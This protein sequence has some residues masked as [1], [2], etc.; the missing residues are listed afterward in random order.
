M[1]NRKVMSIFLSA[2]ALVFAVVIFMGSG[3]A[4]AEPKYVAMIG[5]TS[6][7]TLAEA[8]EAAGT[9][10]AVIRLIDNTTEGVVIPAGADI[11]I[12]LKGH[13][14]NNRN[15]DN[16]E[17][18]LHTFENYGKLELLSS[19]GEG[20]IDNVTHAKACVMNQPGATAVI[21]GKLSLSRSNLPLPA[22]ATRGSWYN[23]CN[24]G[25]MTV[26][27]GVSV[28][29]NDARHTAVTTGFLDVEQLFPNPPEA[30]LTINGGYFTGKLNA[31]K[32]DSAGV[33]EIND[34][35]IENKSGVAIVSWNILKINGGTI[36]A[37]TPLN[38][39]KY[40]W[41]GKVANPPKDPTEKGITEINGGTFTCGHGRTMFTKNNSSI[42]GAVVTI[43]DGTFNGSFSSILHMGK[44]PEGEP[45]LTGYV[46]GG[47]FNPNPSEY[48][49][50]PED[51]D[52]I[53]DENGYTVLADHE[54][55]EADC[56]TP[57]TCSRCGAT[58]GAALGH[59]YRYAGMTWAKDHSA[60]ANFVCKHD[61][62]HTHQEAATVT[63]KTYGNSVCEPDRFTVYTAVATFGGV[64]YKDTKEVGLHSDN[65]SWNQVTY[66]WS[67]DNTL[68]VAMTA[69][70]N[71]GIKEAET[72]VVITSD[73]IKHATCKNEGAMLVTATFPD[74][75]AFVTQ[76]KEVEISKTDDHT[77]G[78]WEHKN[79]TH[80]HKLCVV[81]QE[82][83]AEE[84]HDWDAGKVTTE[85][86]ATATGVRTLT[87]KTCDATKEE[88]I[89]KLQGGSQP[90]SGEASVAPGASAEAADKA[91]TALADDADPK[92]SMFRYL[93]LRSPSQKKNSVK[94]S[95]RKVGGAA[96]Y[97]VYGNACGKRNKMKQ[98]AAVTGNKMN[99]KKVAGKKVK[100]G[101]YYKFVVVALDGN[102]KVITTSKV[103]HVATKGGKVGNHRKVTA[104]AKAGK[105][106][107]A[108]SSI[109]LKKGKKLKLKTALTPVSKK[110]KVRRHV[111]VRY[112]SSNPGV[113]TVTSKGRITARGKGKC[114]IYVYAQNG[115]YK[116]V[117][118]TIR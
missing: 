111:G 8:V 5:G 104:K 7:E 76:E 116:I 88:T 44:N 59:D 2:M 106:V 71:C 10:R 11:T 89:D 98:L 92:E 22:E 38:L 39:N 105:K 13:T 108:V 3:K 45:Y 34:G 63:S 40:S 43:N 30:K 95:W 42:G 81:C 25:T 118:T 113:A 53:Q 14:I 80:H 79:D 68:C 60:T 91:I 62:T 23:I 57:R 47:K 84:E 72:A 102:N 6:Y 93:R 21:S 114:N 29:N 85:P 9:H 99:F 74:H 87:C 32:V 4:F 50:M 46:N 54:W 117:K 27:E 56:T 28:I 15:A 41:E 67:D 73:I 16:P 110:L 20:V 64:E 75:E 55:L 101:T 112:E 61:E 97:I 109:K 78:D 31:F 86:T 58:E 82:P 49:H 103:I 66:T 12:D 100:K 19:D 36:D 51:K 1:K 65:H 26:N 94:I 35:V 90:G 77:H 115:A 96:K 18:G 69:C 52:V 83:V 17:G 37:V 70:A 33:L 107:K 24:R 48:V